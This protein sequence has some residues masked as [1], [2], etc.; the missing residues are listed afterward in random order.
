[1]AE[2]RKDDDMAKLPFTTLRNCNFWLNFSKKSYKIDAI[3]KLYDIFTKQTD[4]F[5]RIVI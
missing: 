2:E 4:A 1:M 3:S 5:P